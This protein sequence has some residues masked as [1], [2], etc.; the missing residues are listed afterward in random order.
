VRAIKPVSDYALR[1]ARGAPPVDITAL[2]GAAPKKRQ[3]GTPA[4]RRTALLEEARGCIADKQW[5]GA[6]AGTLVALYGLFHERVYG[7]WP[8]ELDAPKT[9]GLAT[10]MAG[11]WVR[12]E[13]SGDIQRAVECML[14]CWMREEGRERWRRENNR[15]GQRVGWRLQFSG[16]IASDYRVSLARRSGGK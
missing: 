3:L 10:I 12:D 5:G 8:T 13:F 15:D 11:R 7:A 6:R 9:W 2:V 1:Q 14:W 16:V 4:A